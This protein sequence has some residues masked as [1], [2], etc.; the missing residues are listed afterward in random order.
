MAS[1]VN[2]FVDQGSDYTLT[3]TV[4]DDDGNATDLTGYTVEAYF[5]KWTGANQVYK[6]TTTVTDASAGKVQITL[7]GSVSDDIPSGRYS[8]D[9]VINHASND[10]TRRVIQGSLV[11]NPTASPKGATLLETGNKLLLES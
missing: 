8:Y 3:L 6:F 2:L 4:K 7:K 10:I 5:Q 11:L 1:V 9:V